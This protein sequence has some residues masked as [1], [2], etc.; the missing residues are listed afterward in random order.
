MVGAIPIYF[1]SA[2]VLLCLLAFPFHVALLVLSASLAPLLI[3]DSASVIAWLHGLQFF[4][5][6]ALLYFNVR[7][8]RAVLLFWLLIGLPLASMI[9]Y[10]NL[11]VSLQISVFIALPFV[12]SALISAMSAILVYWLLPVSSPFRQLPALP[13]F[14]KVV[15]EFNLVSVML[16]FFVVLLFLIWRTTHESQVSLNVELDNAL[17]ELNRSSIGLLDDKV[18]TLKS[19]ATL[20]ITETNIQ[21]HANILDTVANASADI[22][23]MIVTDKDG[24]VLLAAPAQYAAKL[25]NLTQLNIAFRDYFQQTKE[26]RVPIVSEAIRGTGLGSLDIVAITAPILSENGFDGIVQAAIKLDRLVDQSVINA[27]Q[28]GQIAVIVTDAMDTIIYSSPQ[29]GLQ[30]LDVFEKKQDERVNIFRIPKLI[31]SEKDYLYRSLSSQTGWKIYTLTEPSRIFKDMDMYFIFM[32][33]IFVQSIILIAILSRGLASNIVRPLRNLEAFIK[34]QKPPDKLLEEAKVSQEMYNVTESVINTQKLSM[35]FQ[36]ELKEQVEEKTKE[37]VSLNS[38]LLRVSRTDSLTGLFNRGA[39]D[40]LAQDAYMYCRRNKKAFTLTLI[41]IDHFKNVNDT[42]GHNAGD[43]CLLDVANVIADMCRRDT[44]II[45]RYGGEEFALFFASD[46]PEQHIEHIKSINQAIGEH[47]TSYNN[48]IIQLT[49][50]CGA[51]RVEEDFS[52]EMIELIS[53]ADEQLYQSK[54]QGRNRVNAVTI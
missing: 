22:E 34:G 5:V 19:T 28:N 26:R 11:L 36:H 1:G 51:V 13:K 31:V 15:L 2:F 23:S 49:V 7:F 46:K 21:N 20:L 10:S 44:D 14:S 42:Y 41:D 50:S 37:L 30:K 6:A 18:H 38:E 9:I 39:F 40:S 12:L 35:D 45:A 43:K 8:L 16:P 4:V 25:P 17:E 52:K 29:L 33:M 27:M 53:L 24:G 47:K 3:F 54:N 48:C 32:I